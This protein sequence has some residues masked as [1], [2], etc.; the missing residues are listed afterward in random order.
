MDVNC[1]TDRLKCVREFISKSVYDYL[2]R[3]ERELVILAVDEICANMVIHSNTPDINNNINVECAIDEGKG[4]ICFEITDKGNKFDYSLY[5]EPSLEEIVKQKRKGGLGLILV[6][7][8]MDSVEFIE[9]GTHNVCR[10]TKK[11]PLQKA[12]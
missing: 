4:C 2:P 3:E 11:I 9:E 12:S 7:R 8:I 5:K 10:L 6:R 1:S